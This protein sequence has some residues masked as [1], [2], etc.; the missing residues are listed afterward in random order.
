MAKYDWYDPN[1]KAKKIEIGTTNLTGADVKFS[2][3]GLGITRYFS[4]NLKVLAYYAIVH[5]E[6]TLLPKFASDIEDNIF[7]LRM[8]LRF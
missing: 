3:L 2:T 4:S 7:T 8:Q 5:N 6:E 1:T